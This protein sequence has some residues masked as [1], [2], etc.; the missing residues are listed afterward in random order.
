MIES[1]IIAPGSVK[2]VLTGKHYNRSIRV[3]KVIYEA[4]ERLR[5]EEFEKS[6][7]TAEKATL[8]SVGVNFKA[9][10]NLGN[11]WENCCST[12][13]I[14]IKRMFN[15]FV[16][17]RGEKNSLFAFWSKYIDMVQLL[18]L[19]IRATRTTD[20]R[21]HLSS[22]RAMIPWFFATDRVNYSRYASCYWMEMM[23]LEKTHPCKCILHNFFLFRPNSF[24]ILLNHFLLIAYS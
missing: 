20:W 12:N 21:L 1:E 18:L 4:L 6:L 19:Q 2:D 17:D 23:C 8:D 11:F 10:S 15:Q 9:N 16:T 3:H 22:L 13:V 7:T 5:W 14:D 24:K